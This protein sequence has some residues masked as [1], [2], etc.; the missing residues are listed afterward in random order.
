MTEDSPEDDY[1]VE[2]DYDG[3]PDEY[4]EW[5]DF[6]GGDDWDQGQYDEVF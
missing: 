6:Q 1:D 4:T 2:D 5:Q 3:Q